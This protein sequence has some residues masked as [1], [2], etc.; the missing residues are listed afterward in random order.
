MSGLPSGLSSLRVASLTPSSPVTEEAVVFLRDEGEGKP[1]VPFYH[2][3]SITLREVQEEFHISSVLE[4]D[5][6]GHVLPRAVAFE[7]PSDVLRSGRH[8]IARRDWQQQQQEEE[9][10]SCVTFRSK[11]LVKE[12][13]LDRSCS[14][15]A[16]TSSPS[17]VM[18]HP[19]TPLPNRRALARGRENTLDSIPGTKRSRSVW[20][21]SSAQEA[22]PV[23]SPPS[24]TVMRFIP[25]AADTSGSNQQTLITIDVLRQLCGGNV[26]AQEAEYKKQHEKAEDIMAGA[27]RLFF[28][29][30]E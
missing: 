22:S 30:K 13:Q 5:S 18:Q 21:D 15:P 10:S 7:S 3:S 16:V 26:E 27:R 4:C 9:G 6:S 19:V 23:A 1:F 17:T 29:E 11:I 8:Y 20:S 12:Y 28:D 25:F 24:A 14:S 2:S